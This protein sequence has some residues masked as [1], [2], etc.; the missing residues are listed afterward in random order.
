MTPSSADDTPQPGRV[1]LVGAGPGDP[2]LITL[3]GAEYLR[4]AD[5]VL[6]DS[7]AN[8]ELLEHAGDAELVCVG[9]HGQTRIWTQEEINSRI[10][11]LALQ[12][13]N[14]VRL[15]GGDPAV[16]ARGVEEMEACLAAGVSYEV[17][18]GVTAALAAGSCAGIPVTHRNMASAVALVT[19]HEHPG[20]SESALD[21]AALAGFPGTLVFYMGVTT[22]PQWTAALLEAG[23]PADTPV[24]IVRHCS[25]PTQQTI[26]CTLED[27]PQRLTTPVK[28]RPPAIF[29]IG[30]VTSL[31]PVLSWFDRRPL[32]GQTI[33]VTRPAHQADGLAT[34]LKQLGAE[35]LYQPAIEITAPADWSPVDEALRELHAFN[36]VV[37]S[38]ANGVH[39]MMRRLFELDLDLRA[40]GGVKLATIGPATSAA[41]KAYHLTADLQPDRFIA[42]EL[43]SQL[44]EDAAGKRFL[45]IRASRGREVLAETL[46]AA[47]GDV[48]QVVVYQSSDV[49]A[50]DPAILQRMQQG[51]I[52]WVTA[53]SSAIGRSLHAMFGAALQQT[54]VVSISPQTSSALRELNIEPAAEATVYNMPGVVDAM[55][56]AVRD[57]K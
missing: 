10:V 3:R 27:V 38:S 11:E 52:N 47:G 39:C 1:F 29:I 53:T 30:A 17:A 15:K 21:Y 22:A 44:A 49:T 4:R 34:P 2:L 31:G 18:P 45:L 8:V 46:E 14:V 43:A 13:R 55:V 6:Y 26:Y 9:K 23:K 57:N 32:S 50:P 42:D 16:F 40:L 35:V 54:Q 48:R 33:L 24:A 41:L 51:E 56:H 36:W 28:I 25:L 20:K 37:F 7:L 19:A 5:V 12:G